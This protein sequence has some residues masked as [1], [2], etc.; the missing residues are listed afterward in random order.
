M[1]GRLANKVLRPLGVSITR[2]KPPHDPKPSFA[3]RQYVN[4]DG[5]FDYERYRSVQIAGNE[6]KLE[7]VFVLEQNITFLAERLRPSAPKFG[8]CHGTRRG[9]EQQWFRNDL[10]GCD[11]I[12]TEISPTASQFPNTIQWDFHDVKPE[13]LNSADFIY[14]NSLDHSYDPDKCLN[15]WMSCIR[16]G[17]VC[18]LEHT[19]M[20]DASCASD[21][22][23][24]GAELSLMPFLI[25]QWGRGRFAATEML[26]APKDRAPDTHFIFVKHN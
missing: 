25:L 11:V 24:F 14:S 7:R 5:S 26:R 2:A 3:L 8:I 6:R 12:G 9:A 17:G 19:R 4:S 15:A 23:P 10:P 13:W 21:L 1:F 18:I 22:D 20:H 16:P